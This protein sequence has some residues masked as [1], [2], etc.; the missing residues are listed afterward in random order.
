MN[1]RVRL[2]TVRYKKRTQ[3]KTKDRRQE[4]RKAEDRM[5]TLPVR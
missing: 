3:E 1:K 5:G 4:D 2:S